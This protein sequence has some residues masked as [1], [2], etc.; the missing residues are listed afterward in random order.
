[1]SLHFSVPY[2]DF[3]DILVVPVFDH[4][5]RKR[6]DGGISCLGFRFRGTSAQEF[7]DGAEYLPASGVK[8]FAAQNCGEIPGGISLAGQTGCHF[9]QNLFSFFRKLCFSRL[10]FPLNQFLE[11]FT[12]GVIDTSLMNA[13]HFQRRDDSVFREPGILPLEIPGIPEI[14]PLVTA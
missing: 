12:C 3:C 7:F 13:L 9:F 2:F 10:F 4:V 14:C 8:R 6:L 11:K 1:M 5:R